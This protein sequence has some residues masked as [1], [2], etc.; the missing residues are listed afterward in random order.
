MCHQQ[1]LWRHKKLDIKGSSTPD[2]AIETVAYPPDAGQAEVATKVKAA[3]QKR[4]KRDV[5]S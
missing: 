3:K 4:S 2:D 1:R 5:V